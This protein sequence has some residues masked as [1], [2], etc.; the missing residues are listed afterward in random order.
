MI[1]HRK[2]LH[3]CNEGKQIMDSFYFITPRYHTINPA[4]M[5]L[6]NSF[7]T[8]SKSSRRPS[9]ECQDKNLNQYQPI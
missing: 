4:H 3:L 9:H 5:R 7:E 1:T 6:P 8:Y 2:H